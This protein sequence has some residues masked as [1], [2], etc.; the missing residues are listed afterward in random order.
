M[1]S[2]VR[3]A[4]RRAFRGRSRTSLI[5]ELLNT[6]PEE[7]RE[8]LNVS[9]QQPC[10][11]CGDQILEPHIDHIEPLENAQTDR[12]IVRLSRLSNLRIVCGAC[13]QKRVRRLFKKLPYGTQIELTLFGEKRTATVVADEG[14]IGPR[15]ERVLRI[16]VELG[17]GVPLELSVSH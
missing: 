9:W 14:N 3:H 4:L 6:T 8:H 2:R 1:A 11:L 17:G 5:Y 12:D 15:G 7:I 13:N 16:S 10:E